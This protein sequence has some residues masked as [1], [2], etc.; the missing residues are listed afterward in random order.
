MKSSQLQSIFS[1]DV[2]QIVQKMIVNKSV[3]NRTKF[4]S[5]I[6]FWLSCEVND[7]FFSLKIDQMIKILLIFFSNF[8]FILSPRAL[9]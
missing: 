9:C 4:V 2:S 1:S 8:F 5:K 3:C 7:I 6:L